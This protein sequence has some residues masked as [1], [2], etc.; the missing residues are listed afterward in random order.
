MDEVFEKRLL[1]DRETLHALQQRRNGPSAV[2]LTLHLGA[3]LVTSWVIVAWSQSFLT[4]VMLTVALSWMVSGMF[5][6]FHECVHKTAFESRGL[7]TLGACLSGLLFGMAPATYH[8]FHFEHHRFT[9]NPERDPEIMTY[10][11]ALA[12]WPETNR[13]WLRLAGGTPLIQLK[14]AVLIRFLKSEPKAGKPTA[15]WE[16][17]GARRREV[18]WQSWLIV[19]FWVGLVI[20]AI[21]VT[22]A[23]WW[24]LLAFVI[25]NAWQLLWTS[26]EHT[27]LPLEGTILNRTR[28]VLSNR[29]VRWWNWNMNF[30]AEHHAWPGIPWHQLPAAHELV[31]SNLDHL[32]SGYTALHTNVLHQH[33]MPTANAPVDG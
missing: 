33:N 30:H 2:R 20:I 8:A 12:V 1:L 23:V 29:F 28:T 14:Y 10:P 24:L 5:G 32:V 7:N 9:H 18:V 25:S 15:L 11:D 4:S 3:V 19:G 17:T 22:P 6:P 31:K 13:A 26:A 16:P 27:G 21:T